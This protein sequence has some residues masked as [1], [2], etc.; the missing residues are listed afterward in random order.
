MA[1]IDSNI[2]LGVKP[3]QLE[4]PLNAFAQAAQIQNYQ[5]QNELANRAIEQ[6]D[7]LNKAY[8]ASMNPQ[9][10]EIDAN[11]LRQNIAGANLGSK[12]SAVEKSL[13]ET[14]KTRGEVEKNEF[15]LRMDKAN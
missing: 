4:N 8:A 11:R 2:A 3:V 9:T 15:Q 12:L 5:R 1:T 14:R 10:G 6:E 7:A 13:L